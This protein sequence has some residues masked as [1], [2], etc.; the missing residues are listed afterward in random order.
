MAKDDKD[1]KAVLERLQ[2]ALVQT[3]AWTID[4]GR[5][6]LIVFEGRDSAGKDGAIKRLTE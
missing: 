6:T 1:Y 5:R 3:Q 2:V 4:K